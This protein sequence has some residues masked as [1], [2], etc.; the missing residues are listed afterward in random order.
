MPRWSKWLGRIHRGSVM[1]RRTQKIAEAISLLP[2]YGARILDVGSGNGMLAKN[3]MQLRPDVY[4]EGVDIMEW[5]DP[6]IPVR[7]FDGESIPARVGEWDYCLVSDVLHHCAVPENL[8]SEMVR[9]S[10]KGLILKDHVAETL[11]DRAVLSFMDWFGNRGH[12]VGLTYNY[13]SWRQWEAAFCRNGISPRVTQNRLRLYPF[14]FSM[15][16]ERDL[17]FLSLLEKD[18]AFRGIDA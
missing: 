14:P 15:V 10:G 2:I 1:E 7:K 11:W 18:Q 4:I 3:V 8:L 17:H 6:F 5:P 13:W 16:F 9:V 12:G